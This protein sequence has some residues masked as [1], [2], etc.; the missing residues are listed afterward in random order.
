MRWHPPT[1][2]V[3]RVIVWRLFRVGSGRKAGWS[4]EA[5]ARNGRRLATSIERFS[6]RQQC[7]WAAITFGRPATYPEFNT[8]R[9][10]HDGRV[11][12]INWSDP[13]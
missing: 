5:Q 10:F 6:S 1:E 8:I 13:A 11:L 2:H 3:S 9:A 4:W 7:L 12:V